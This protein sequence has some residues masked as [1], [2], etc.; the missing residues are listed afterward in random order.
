M[1]DV[2]SW[3]LI[4]AKDGFIGHVVSEVRCKSPI[5]SYTPLVFGLDLKCLVLWQLLLLT[6][7]APTHA[8]KYL[9]KN[10][11]IYLFVSPI[12][13]GS[14]KCTQGTLSVKGR[15]KYYLKLV[16]WYLRSGSKYYANI[17]DP[18]CSLQGGGKCRQ[19]KLLSN[20]PGRAVRGG[21]AIG[22]F[23]W[24]ALQCSAI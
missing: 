20:Q 13:A 7:V 23:H 21:G 16:N 2:K 8:Q 19:A 3:F 9:G 6:C 4:F 10:T 12:D 11:F 17:C 15:K 14:Q 22:A 1:L 24:S 18:T 5:A